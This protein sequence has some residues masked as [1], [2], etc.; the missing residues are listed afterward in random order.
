MLLNKIAADAKTAEMDI[1]PFHQFSDFAHLAQPPLKSDLISFANE[2]Y[3]IVPQAVVAEQ[4]DAGRNPGRQG[5]R[6]LADR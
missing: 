2:R 1:K 4:D 5:D 6:R 3:Q